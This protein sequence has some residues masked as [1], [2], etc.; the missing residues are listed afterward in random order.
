MVLF[1]GLRRRS[2]ARRGDVLSWRLPPAPVIY[3]SRTPTSSAMV[4]N[5]PLTTTT[6]AEAM[7]FN[8][9]HITNSFMCHYLT[10]LSCGEQKIHYKWGYFCHQGNRE[11]RLF[12]FPISLL[13]AWVGFKLKGCDRAQVA[14][15]S[16]SG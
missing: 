15:E 14:G 11:K 1:G 8:C 2:A 3:I 16:L 6:T 9:W 13:L 5:D 10:I 4:G 7:I 12:I